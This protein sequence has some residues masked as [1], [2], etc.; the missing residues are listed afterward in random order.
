MATPHNLIWAGAGLYLGATSV[1]APTPPSSAVAD[2]IID[3][4]PIT[5]ACSAGSRQEFWDA[6]TDGEAMRLDAE[7]ETLTVSFSQHDIEDADGD[8]SLLVVQPE[9]LGHFTPE[10]GAPVHL[11]ILPAQEGRFSPVEVDDVDLE[12]FDL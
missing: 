7:L 4:A 1:A 3:G 9:E 11:R 2:Y 5:L 8:Y 6:A 10:Y 12:I